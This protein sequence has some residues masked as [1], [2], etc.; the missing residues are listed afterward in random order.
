M[1]ASNKAYLS[2]V[3]PVFNEEKTIRQIVEKI[4]SLDF[5][6]ELII[7]DDGSSDKTKEFLNLFLPNAKIRYTEH[8]T[9][10]GKGACLKEGFKQVSGDIVTIQ[11]ADLEYEPSELKGLAAPILAGK[12][13]VVYGSRFLTIKPSQT[14][15]WHYL[16]NKVLTTLTN[17]LYATRLTDMETCYKVFSSDIAAGM[18]ID[19]KGFAVEPELTAKIVKKGFTI[20]ELPISY[21]GRSYAEGKKIRWVHAFST[22]AAIIKYRF[23]D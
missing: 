3:M 15:F 16:G 23:L 2:V 19:S 20:L 22:I 1:E 7:I 11:D 13:K 8:K 4:L 18:S 9:N 12:A 14:Y 17:L 5:V 21:R 6:K 10:K